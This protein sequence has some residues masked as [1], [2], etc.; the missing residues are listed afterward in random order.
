MSRVH[1]YHIVDTS[2]HVNG[3]HCLPSIPLNCEVTL[4]AAVVWYK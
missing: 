4:L 1:I 3:P 2:R